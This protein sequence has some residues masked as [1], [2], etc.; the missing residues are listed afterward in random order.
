MGRRMDKE[1]KGPEDM[2]CEMEEQ[3]DE[4]KLMAMQRKG[5]DKRRSV[6]MRNGTAMSWNGAESIRAEKER[7]WED[8]K[9]DGTATNGIVTRRRAMDW[10]GPEIIWS[11]TEKH[12][13][14]KR[15]SD[16]EGNRQG[17]KWAVVEMEGKGNDTRWDKSK[18]QGEVRKW[19]DKIKK[20]KG[21]VETG[22]E[23]NWNGTEGYGQDA[24]W[25]G[26]VRQG[27]EKNWRDL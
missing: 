20:W 10:R 19:N 21:K 1:W 3:G 23:R 17:Q 11:E 26:K 2:W 16:T 4:H 6:R 22:F 13:L 25:Y 15:R 14:E 18:R 8:L 5:R 7:T 9:C 24:I 12:R 27:V